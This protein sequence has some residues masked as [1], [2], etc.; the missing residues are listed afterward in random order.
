MSMQA[1]ILLGGQGTRLKTLYP[2]I[3]KALVPV[4]GRPFIE[5]QI[6][7]L[8]RNGMDSFHLAAGHKGKQIT[9]WAAGQ[10][11]ISVTCEEVPLGTGGALRFI[12]PHIQSE[13]CVVCNGDTLLPNLCFQGLE[14]TLQNRSND[15]KALTVVV[16]T[17]SPV[18]GGHVAFNASGQVTLF[19]E[20]SGQT[21]G[22]MNGGVYIMKRSLLERIP[23]HTDCSLERDLFPALVTERSLLAHVSEPP[24]LDMG[25]PEGLRTMTDYLQSNTASGQTLQ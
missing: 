10:E 3:P 24:L 4:A 16:Q 25:T 5:W 23:A 7:W 13:T 11:N 15:W 6:A 12:M 22:W 18:S 20:K 1:I 21:T 14:K 19:N 9:Q 2:E 17:N 8:R